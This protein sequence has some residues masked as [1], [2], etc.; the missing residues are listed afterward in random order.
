MTTAQLLAL[1]L[2][3]TL[4]AVGSWAAA[5]VVS[6]RPAASQRTARLA[7]GLA[8]LGVVVLAAQ[9]LLAIVLWPSGWWFV[10]E[11]VLLALPVGLAGAGVAIVV[12]VPP[13]I[14]RARGRAIAV[15]PREST[16]LLVAALTAAAAAAAAAAQYVVGYPMTV[17]P[18]IALVVLVALGSGLGHA[19]FAAEARRLV[20]GLAALAGLCLVA[21]LG[22]SWLT[23]VASPVAL[24]NAHAHAAEPPAPAGTVSVAD[25]R[26]ADDAPGTVRHFDLTAA[27]Q[28]VTLPS[29]A[30]V[31]AWTFGSVPGPEIRVTQG[32]LVEVTLHNTDIAEGVTLHWHGYD[33]PN[34]EDGVAG[35]TQDA[36]LPGDSFTYRFEASDAGTYWYHTHQNSADGVRRGLYG[37]LIV[38][39]RSGV[40]EDVD[41]V[42]PVHTFGHSVLLDDSDRAET[43]VVQA[44]DSVRVRLINTDQVPQR[45][46]ITGAP[47]EVAAVDGRDIA[48]PTPLDGAALRIPAG[49]RMDVTVTIP[50]GGALL[51]VDG[52]SRSSL[53]LAPDGVTGGGLKPDRSA[54]DVDLL[55]YGT[56][57][58][59][60]LPHGDGLVQATMVL[61]RLPRFLSGAPINGYAVNGAVFPHIP[62]IEVTEGNVLELTV[63]N[64]G[65]DTHPMHIHGHHVLV[66]SRNGVA[67]TGAPLWLDTFDVQPG[68]VWV[69]ALVADNPGIW[70]DHCHNLE[71]A[72]EGMMMALHYAGVTSPFDQGGQHGN[73][74]E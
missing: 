27:Q 61:D 37:T 17:V 71:H 8:G 11:K 68:E 1:D 15:R 50:A 7:L 65:S 4:V 3:A 66:L 19:L 35:V 13:L 39:P 33:V 70:M 45:F 34:G 67:A 6:T 53:L 30:T 16:A 46:R 20:V 42:V 23:S 48:G 69:V 12:A 43:L 74:S 58:A 14:A 73:H 9:V 62:S 25:L 21:S 36:V 52:T 57:N 44:G 5:V 56:P 2:V 38:E 49:G 41:L 29:G 28:T 60:A 26:T 10:Q 31:N 51:T 32:D 72:A 54:A 40:P 18:A 22:F 64:R 24:A 47:F 63:A 59:A 55:A